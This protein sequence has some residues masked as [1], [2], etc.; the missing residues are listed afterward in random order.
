MVIV[1]R[2]LVDCNENS[3]DKY[4]MLEKS[5]VCKIIY[6]SIYLSNKKD[7]VCLFIWLFIYSFTAIMLCLKNVSG[8]EAPDFI[9]GKADT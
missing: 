2:I 3:L 9:P 6:L 7:F 4:K 1:S 8:Y 5:G